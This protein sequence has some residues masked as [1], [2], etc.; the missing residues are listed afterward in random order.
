MREKGN[1]NLY[2]LLVDFD[3]TLKPLIRKLNFNPGQLI[4]FQ[5]E[6]Y[7]AYVSSPD[8]NAEAGVSFFI[9]MGILPQTSK[10]QPYLKAGAGMVYITQH[11]REQSTQFNFIDSGGIGVH[12]FLT[13]N[14]NLTLE[15]RYRHLSNAGIKHPNSG[16]NT[17]FVVAGISYQF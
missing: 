4:Q 10:F 8:S 6:P 17:V 12:Y 13:K 14:T 16:I 2:P 7:I 9:K 11:T 1:Y 15:G 5:I 3:F